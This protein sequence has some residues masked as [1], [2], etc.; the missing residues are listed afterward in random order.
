[1]A[2]HAVRPIIYLS[3]LLHLLLS[4]ATAQPQPNS[5]ASPPN[6]QLPYANFTPSMA[7]IIV[8]LIAALFLM[9]FFSIYLRHCTD[10][11]GAG[12]SVRPLGGI[13]DSL[14]RRNAA[15]GLDPVVIETFPT[16]EYSTVKG[17]KIGKGALECAVCLNEF[18][19]EDT[20]RL[21]PKC[22]HV[23]HPDCIDVWLGSHVTC[24]VCRA[25]LV[26]Q[27]GETIEVPEFRA[28]N[29]DDQDELPNPRNDDVSIRVG[30]GEEEE[31]DEGA[32][33][34]PQVMDRSKSVNQNRPPRTRSFQFRAKMFG[35]FPRSH[36]TGHSVVSPGDNT[37]RF[38]LR[39]PE[40]VRKQVMKSRTLNR[41]T[42]CM[43][44]LPSDQGSGSQRYRPGLGE[45]S[46][47]GQRSFRRLDQGMKSGRSDRW[48]FSMAPP[49]FSRSSSTVRSPKGMGDGSTSSRRTALK[50]PS[51]KC[52]EPK[53]DHEPG[54]ISAELARLPV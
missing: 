18:E 1:M 7:I 39:L 25:N 24:P 8:V 50:L 3:L 53:G 16:F 47:T 28:D 48:V 11:T 29:S 40:D 10:S 52:L 34:P 38:T 44:V 49:F 54:L 41:T 4:P 14:R 6:T 43:V 42:S 46:S 31:H 27:P 15:R 36:S 2:V 5:N 19:D 13:R 20:L 32:I 17:M 51:F 9:G 35:K 12:G 26:P 22:D 23:F 30:E 37:D 45:G 21:I 33:T